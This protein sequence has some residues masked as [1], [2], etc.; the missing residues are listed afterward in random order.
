MIA[1]LRGTVVRSRPESMVVRAEGTG[2][3]LHV[4]V[5]ARSVTTPGTEVVLHTHLQ[6]GSEGPVLA[7][8]ETLEELEIFTHLLEVNGVGTRMAVRVLS[9]HPAKRIV[10]A[11]DREDPAAF[12]AVPGVGRKLA[13]RIILELRGKLV[14]EAGTEVVGPADEGVSDALEALLTLGY[15]RAEATLALNQTAGEAMP[16]EARIAAALRDLGSRA[17]R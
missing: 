2:L 4:T 12:Q 5:P 7:G 14:P 1:E 11:L 16:V 15:T 9:T 6:I 10:E 3:G 13:N 17:V 8:F